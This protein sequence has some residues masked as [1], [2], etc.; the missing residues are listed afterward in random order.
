MLATEGMVAEPLAVKVCW[1]VWTLCRDDRYGLDA[2]DVCPSPNQSC[3]DDFEFV[4]RVGF[5]RGGDAVFALYILGH[6]PCPPSLKRR[7]KSGKIVWRVDVRVN[8]VDPP[9]TLRRLGVAASWNWSQW[10]SEGRQSSPVGPPSLRDVVGK[11]RKPRRGRMASW[12]IDGS[13]MVRVTV[14]RPHSMG[15]QVPAASLS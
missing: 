14:K 10:S 12:R 9:G 8:P 6:L 4:D 11:T 5:N 15:S 7:I 1:W 13:E 2:E 3:L